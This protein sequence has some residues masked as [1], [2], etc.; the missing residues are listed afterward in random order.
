MN[1]QEAWK[2][3]DQLYNN[4]PLVCTKCGK[5]EG[6]SFWRGRKKTTV[7]IGVGLINRAGAVSGENMNL[8]CQRCEPLLKG[9]GLA[10]SLQQTVLW[11]P[12]ELAAVR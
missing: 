5:K 11:E 9:R 2:H 3:A 1:R 4:G 12:E 10:D 7:R 6:D 8:F